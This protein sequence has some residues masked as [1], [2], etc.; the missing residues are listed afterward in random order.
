ML[1]EPDFRFHHLGLACRTLKA[2]LQAWEKL[3]Y[4]LEGEI[5][6]DPIQKIRGAFLTGAGPRLELLEPT[7]ADSPVSGFVAR[8]VKLYHQGFEVADFDRAMTQLASAGAKLT[9]PPA[10]ATAFGGRRI[11]FFMAQGLNLIEIIETA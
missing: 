8:G 11:A 4:A 7:A 5:F 6:E 9:A 2:E 10:P 1:R 3:G